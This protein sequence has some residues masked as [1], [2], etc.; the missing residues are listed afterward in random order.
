MGGGEGGGVN[1]AA[2]GDV[3]EEVKMHEEVGANERDGDVCNDE[4]PLEG[5]ATIGEL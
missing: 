5:T 3:D 1:E 4:L 2:V